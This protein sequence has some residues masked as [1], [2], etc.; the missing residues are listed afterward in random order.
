MIPLQMVVVIGTEVCLIRTDSATMAVA[1][2]WIGKM[3]ALEATMVTDLSIRIMM[4]MESGN[5]VKKVLMN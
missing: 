1:T 2:G 4:K 3:S 5:P